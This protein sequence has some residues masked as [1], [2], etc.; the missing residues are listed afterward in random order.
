MKRRWRDPARRDSYPPGHARLRKILAPEVAAGLKD[1]AY[2]GEPILPGEAWDLGHSENK[3]YYNGP[4]HA[5]CNRATT[6]RAMRHSRVWLE[7]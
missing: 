5:R 7:N 6:T 2:C 4:E 3:K 1:C